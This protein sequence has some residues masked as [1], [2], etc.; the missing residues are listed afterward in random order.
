MRHKTHELKLYTV[1]DVWRGV[2]SGAKNFRRLKN[3][4]SYMRRLGR[5]RN[6]IEDDIQLFESPIRLPSRTSR[7][8]PQ[9]KK[10]SSH[11][12]YPKLGTRRS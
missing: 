3:A 12:S 5:G 4:R 8:R 9:A 1:V 10:G 6:L 2:A 7:T 11:S